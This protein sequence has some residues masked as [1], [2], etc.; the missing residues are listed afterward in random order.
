MNTLS[1][2]LVIGLLGFFILAGQTHASVLV[3]PYL[4]LSIGAQG[5]TRINSATYD[6]SFS[7]ATYGGRVGYEYL[8][9]MA[10]IDYSHQDF[11]MVRVGPG[12]STTKPNASRN[13]VGIFVG[14]D[15]PFLLRGWATYFLGGQMDLGSEKF[16]NGRGLELG[17]GF[18]ALPFLS[19]NLSLRNI[20]YYKYTTTTP[21]TYGSNKLKISEVIFAASIP[22]TI[23][24]EI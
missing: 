5:K 17:L 8:G 16:S 10:G 6:Y 15:F 21:A 1:K 19:F 14:Y 2:I 20:E 12:R 9:V 23:L 7:S 13:Q 3:E 24:D 22:L 11:T 18:K 4:G